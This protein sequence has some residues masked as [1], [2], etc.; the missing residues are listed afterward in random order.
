MLEKRTIL[1]TATIGLDLEDTLFDLFGLEK[2][3]YLTFDEVLKDKEARI[4]PQLIEY[5]IEKDESAYWKVI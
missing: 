3:S 1:L 5:V 4:C 2:A